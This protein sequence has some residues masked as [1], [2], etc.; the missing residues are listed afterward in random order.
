MQRVPYS[1]GRTFLQAFRPAL[2]LFTILSMLR[3]GLVRGRTIGTATAT[4]H[5][6]CQVTYVVASMADLVD[7]ADAERYILGYLAVAA[8]LDASFHP[9]VREPATP[10]EFNMPLVYGRWGDGYSA[11]GD[12]PVALPSEA[13][14]GRAMTLSIP[15]IGSVVG[16]TDKY[17]QLA[18]RILSFLS[19]QI[20]LFPGDVV[21][22]GQVA[23]PVTVPVDQPLE[24]DAAV[25]VEVEGIGTIESRILDERVCC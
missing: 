25:Q 16:N 15:G 13:V 21:T 18:P 22:L 8:L 4:L 6:A 17:L 9:P 12:R 19:G 3:V 2:A 11:V 1:L 5:P 7:E 23:R 10:Q 14:P 20:T 24:R